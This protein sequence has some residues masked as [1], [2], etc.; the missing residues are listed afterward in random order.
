MENDI[1]KFV[2][3]LIKNT[4]GDGKEDNPFRAKA[5]T[6]L[7]YALTRYIV[8]EGQ[9]KERNI[10]TL[11]DMINSME[12]REDDENFKNAVDPDWFPLTLDSYGRLQAMT[13]WSLTA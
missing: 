10:N 7:Y 3:A 13:K 2:N 9:E 5:K 12:T 1:L 8:L 4:K 11:V 6:L